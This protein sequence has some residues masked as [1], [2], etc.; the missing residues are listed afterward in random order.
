MKPLT[1][2]YFL[3]AAVFFLALSA[4]YPAAAHGGEPRL[5]ISAER[6]NPGAVVNVRGVEFEYDDVVTLALIG[7]EGEIVLG[8]TTANAEGE[9]THIAVLPA[10]LAEGVYYFRGTTIHHWVMSPPLTVWGT[11]IEEGGGQ[12]PRDEDDGL[13][14]PMPTFAPGVV[15]GGVSQAAAQPNPVPATASNRNLA[16]FILIGLLVVGI[17]IVSGLKLVGKR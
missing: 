15:P 16:G 7:T 5:E 8:E 6:L 11:A 4:V 12:G 10:D 9:F 14:A 17:L 3:L 2:R 1:V 13:L